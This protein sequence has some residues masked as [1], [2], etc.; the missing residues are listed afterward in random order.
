MG[1]TDPNEIDNV[2]ET[3]ENF[4]NTVTILIKI[5]QFRKLL[6]QKCEEPNLPQSNVTKPLVDESKGLRL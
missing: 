6:I 2:K 5:E 3:I 4:Y 1:I